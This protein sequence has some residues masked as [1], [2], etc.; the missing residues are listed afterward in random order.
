MRL[1]MGRYFNAM[2]HELDRRSSRLTANIKSAGCAAKIGSADLKRIV[3]GLALLPC[4]NLLTGIENFE[5]AAVYKLSEKL[6]LVQ[7]VDFFPPVVD[8]PYLYGRIAA[9]N[10]LSDIYAMGAH[11]IMALNILV[12]PTCDYDLDIAHQIL[13]GGSDVLAAAGAALAGGHS[14]QGPEPVYGLSVTGTID[15]A[16]VLTNCGAKEKDVIVLC[17]SIGTGVGL[18]GLKGGLLSESAQEALLE[19]LTMLNDKPLKTSQ[20]FSLHAATDVTGF[21][22]IGHLHEMGAGSGLAVRLNSRAVPF[23]P[24]VLQLA[25]QG[26]VPAGCYGNRKSFEQFASY[27]KDAN[28]AVVDLLFDPQT[29]GGLM[30][31][32]PPEESES[33]VAALRE[34][35]MTGWVIGE[36]FE[37]T[38]GMV[39][40][41]S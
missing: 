24:E 3:Q 25:E 20:K 39:E 1:S 36:F 27:I 26:F 17:K 38:P 28:E 7:T 37:G 35:G 6:A 32:I 14:I 2:D 16:K 10:A 13:R 40:V 19:S 5:D 9:T 8:D 18:L 4:E 34:N 41:I 11:P 21:G 29:S 30:F 15:P 33:L 31:A 23:L 22:L 12:F